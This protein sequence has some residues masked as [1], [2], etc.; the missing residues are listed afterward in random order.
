MP[1]V[2]PIQFKAELGWTKS[3]NQRRD[4]VLVLAGERCVARRGNLATR[5]KRTKH[6]RIDACP[7]IRRIHA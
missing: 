1:I 5:A 2:I 3:I 7:P 6:R 4:F